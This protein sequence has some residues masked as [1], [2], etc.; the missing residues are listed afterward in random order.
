[1]KT[2]QN[3]ME[4][5]TA[6]RSSETSWGGIVMA[7]RKAIAQIALTHQPS[8]LIGPCTN[9]ELNQYFLSAV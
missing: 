9:P 3:A 2:K 5:S 4:A 8:Q 7:P 6:V 1:M